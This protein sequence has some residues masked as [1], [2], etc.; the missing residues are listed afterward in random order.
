MIAFSMNA[1]GETMDA[2]LTYGERDDKEYADFA[3]DIANQAALSFSIESDKG[4]EDGSTGNFSL[5]AQSY[6]DD[7]I[8]N[9]AANYAE[10]MGEVEFR[11]I[12][13]LANAIDVA[14]LEG[15]L[16]DQTAA[17]LN[18]ALAGILNYLG[19]LTPE[20]AAA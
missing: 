20:V 7:T 11:T 13:N 17:E 16:D 3:M 8:V 12:E 5:S 10:A 14:N 9:I 19:T 4:V 2:S 15:G 6:A 1:A 18:N